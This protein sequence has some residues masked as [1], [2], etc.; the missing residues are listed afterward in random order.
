M[1]ESAPAPVTTDQDYA[2]AQYTEEYYRQV[3]RNIA[4]RSHAWRLRWLDECLQ[5]GPGQRIVDLGCGPGVLARHLLERGAEVHGVDLSPIAI[6]FAR[7]FNAH[8]PGA[9]FE[10]ADASAC[11]HLPDGSSDKACSCDV[12][13]HCGYEVMRAIFR[14]ARRLV[15]PGGLYFIYTPNPRHWLEVLK[16]WRILRPDPSH[17][18]LRTAEVI[19]DALRQ[20]GWEIARQVRPPSMLPV[21]QWLEKAWSYVPVAGELGVYRVVILARKG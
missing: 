19:A 17:T 16:K 2:T 21:I 18:G 13:E 3:L 20:E 15:R 11:T 12:T 14:E 5:P 4:Y 9:H 6:R 10:V 1:L 8:F 7:E